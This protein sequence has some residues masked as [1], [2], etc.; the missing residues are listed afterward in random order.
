MSLWTTWI[1]CST[2]KHYLMWSINSPGPKSLDLGSSS[3]TLHFSM[4]NWTALS[5][6]IRSKGIL[7]YTSGPM[8]NIAQS[9]LMAT[10]IITS[11]IENGYPPGFF[12]ISLATN[13][14]PI[15]HF[16]NTD[17]NPPK[18]IS[19]PGWL[20]AHPGKLR[21]LIVSLKRPSTTV[22]V[23]ID[24][25]PPTYSNLTHSL[26]CRLANSSGEKK[27]IRYFCWS[28]S[29]GSSSHPKSSGFPMNLKYS[30]TY[31][32]PIYTYTKLLQSHGTSGNSY[33]G[34]KIVRDK[35]LN[36]YRLQ[37]AFGDN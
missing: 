6:M 28:Y 36:E 19:W 10:S 32:L 35:D 13:S 11:S 4:W 30:L 17:P 25:A 27:W 29:L 34:S 9:L 31:L 21:R 18:P 8:L 23:T 14:S 26:V 24:A 3:I 37:I 2:L 22:Y 12:L 7:V 33:D 5:Y 16:F 20:G 15:T 1:L